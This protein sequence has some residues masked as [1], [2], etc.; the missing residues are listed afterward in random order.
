MIKNKYGCDWQSLDYCPKTDSSWLCVAMGCD[1]VWV[2]E[3]LG[4]VFLRE[5]A[6]FPKWFEKNI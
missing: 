6:F 2:D 4:K 3:G 5:G 1:Q